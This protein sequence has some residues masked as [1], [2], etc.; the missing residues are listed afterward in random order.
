VARIELAKSRVDE[1]VASL[2][3]IVFDE[4]G[5]GHFKPDTDEQA[6]ALQLA[7]ERFDWELH[8][9]GEVVCRIKLFHYNKRQHD[10]DCAELVPKL[11]FQRTPSGMMAICNN[12][13]RSEDLRHGLDILA[14]RYGW[15][16]NHDNLAVSYVHKP[17]HAKPMAKAA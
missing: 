2:P 3:R 8:D 13:E 5:T 1:L 10:K 4:Q 14:E 11:Y 6:E 16:V 12:E 15:T 17:Y 7:A 9:D